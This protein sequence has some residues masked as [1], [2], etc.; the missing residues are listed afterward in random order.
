MLVFSDVQ[1]LCISATYIL[2][3][4]FLDTSSVNLDEL[5]FFD[6]IFEEQKFKKTLNKNNLLIFFFYHLDFCIVSTKSQ[7]H[8][9]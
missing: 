1:S 9:Y 6:C 8:S 3:K 7:I 4:R 5:S 2:N